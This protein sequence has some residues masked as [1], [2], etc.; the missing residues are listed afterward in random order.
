MACRRGRA[1][2]PFAVLILASLVVAGCMKDPAAAPTPPDANQLHGTIFQ[3]D[4]PLAGVAL[5]LR[6][7][8][9]QA[10]TTSGSDGTFRFDAV[11][12]GPCT[13][14]V[15]PPAGGNHTVN[16]QCPGRLNVRLPALVLPP[17]DAAGSLGAGPTAP[18]TPVAP[19][20]FNR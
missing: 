6:H 12:P 11:A 15:A 4:L 19:T 14:L 8:G 1:V 17:T 20:T 13:I 2:K 3:G 18:R 9:G 16:T 5:S 7:A 10:Q